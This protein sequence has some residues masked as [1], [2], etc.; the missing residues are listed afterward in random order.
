MKY[1]KQIKINSHKELSDIIME[2]HKFGNNF[3]FYFDLTN[4]VR[5]FSN[6]KLDGFV[7][8]PFSNKFIKCERVRALERQTPKQ[9]Q[10]RIEK[11][12]LHLAKKGIE[13]KSDGR[14]CNAKSDYYLNIFSFSSQRSFR[15]NIKHTI[16]YKEKSGQFDSYGLS[17]NGT[18]LPLF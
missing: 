4:S 10:K 16:V 14:Q 6:S 13:Y 3:A 18:T 5:I 11:L 1:Y 15:L 7:E 9:R 2:C 17:K 12:K 8:T